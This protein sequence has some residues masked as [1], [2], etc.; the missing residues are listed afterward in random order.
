[1]FFEKIYEYIKIDYHNY[2]KKKN[3]VIDCD[4]IRANRVASMLLNYL[5]R[6]DRN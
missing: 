1:M 2:K 5:N 6:K 4:G 3:K